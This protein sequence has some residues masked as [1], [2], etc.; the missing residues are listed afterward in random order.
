MAKGTPV[1]RLAVQRREFR[2]THIEN[3]AHVLA[4]RWFCFYDG[5]SH[6]LEQQAELLSEDVTV[7]STYGAVAGDIAGRSAY[8]RSVSSFAPG[9]NS[10]HLQHLRIR[11]LAGGRTTFSM[12]VIYQ[13]SGGSADSSSNRIRYRGEL[14]DEGEFLPRIRAIRIDPYAIIN[15]RPFEEAYPMNR[16]SSLIYCWLSVLEA[17][18]DNPEPLRELIAA[19]GFELTTV[20]GHRLTAF[21]QVAD[22]ALGE[23]ESVE[24]SNAQ[25]G[26]IAI[27][28]QGDV[29]AVASDV[30]WRQLRKDRRQQIVKARYEWVMRDRGARYPEVVRLTIDA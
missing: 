21:E 20:S 12:E 24:M 2:H 14:A 27:E 15:D 16:A 1:A 23:C 19:D 7:S 9:R 30:S 25:V 28:A 3:R 26:N 8:L 10:H 18:P 17:G 5:T 4:H 13:H 11:S 22:W 6:N 29:Y